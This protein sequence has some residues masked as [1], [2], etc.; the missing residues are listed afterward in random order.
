MNDELI[1]L[2]RAAGLAV[3]LDGVIGR[4]QYTSVTGSLEALQRF[5]DAYRAALE[6]DLKDRAR[7][8]TRANQPTE[9]K[10]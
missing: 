3:K 1:A 9:K 6:Q 7:P 8:D 5:G 10:V 4:Q 2:A